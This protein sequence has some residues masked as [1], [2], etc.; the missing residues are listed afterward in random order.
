M[1][2]RQPRLGGEEKSIRIHTHSPDV[3]QQMI[4]SKLMAI[5]VD[6]IKLK[7]S[8]QITIMRTN[9]RPR[10]CDGGEMSERDSQNEILNS[11]QS[12]EPKAPLLVLVLAEC[13]GVQRCVATS[14]SDGPQNGERSHRRIEIVSSF[15]AHCNQTLKS[16]DRSHTAA[17]PPNT[18]AAARRSLTHS[19]LSFPFDTHTHTGTVPF[20]M[21]SPAAGSHQ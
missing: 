13:V 5:N 3:S 20:H 8:L 1:V 4:N 16:A 7:R 11:R 10:S 17:H 14:H 9:C 6:Y 19:P 21:Y 2:S 15:I 18:P 12:M